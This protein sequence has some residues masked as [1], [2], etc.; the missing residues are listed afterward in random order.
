MFE[1]GR[2]ILHD[3]FLAVDD[4][5]L[6]TRVFHDSVLSFF[7]LHAGHI[8]LL[9]VPQNMSGGI[10]SFPLLA[11]P[12]FLLAGTLMNELG[13][14]DRLFTFALALVGHITL[15]VLMVE[16][17][18]EAKTIHQRPCSSTSM[19]DTSDSS[20]NSHPAQ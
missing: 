7:Y 13:I 2:K 20:H 18:A 19:S 3:I 12:L 14:T 17:A 5:R 6:P 15:G 9:V 10:D 8:D 16:D 1:A 4:D 11:I